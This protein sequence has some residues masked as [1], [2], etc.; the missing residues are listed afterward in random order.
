MVG[1]GRGKGNGEDRL[2]ESFNESKLRVGILNLDKSD[3]NESA[4]MDGLPLKL[5]PPVKGAEETNGV[6]ACGAGCGVRACGMEEAGGG[7]GD[8]SRENGA[9][10]S[11]TTV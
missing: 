10:W 4:D 2:V 5:F 11:K 3:R 1:E 8:A 7:G 6:C 9:A